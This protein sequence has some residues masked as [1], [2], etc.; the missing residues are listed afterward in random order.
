M[1]KLCLNFLFKNVLLVFSSSCCC[2]FFSYL[3]WCVFNNDIYIVGSICN[4]F[5]CGFYCEVVE[6]CYFVFSNC[7]VIVLGYCIDFVM[8]RF[9]RIFFKFSCVEKLYCCWWC[10]DYEGER[11]VFKYCDYNW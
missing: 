4:Y 6:V 2:F 3:G 11:F 9:R 7:F 8:V 5:Y 10:F 1:F